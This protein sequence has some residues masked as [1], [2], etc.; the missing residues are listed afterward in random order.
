MK[1]KDKNNDRL[2]MVKI[3]PKIEEEKLLLVPKGVEINQEILENSSCFEGW[4][5]EETIVVYG[6]DLNVNP[7]SNLEIKSNIEFRE[8]FTSIDDLD[9]PLPSNLLIL[10]EDGCIGTQGY[11]T[12]RKRNS[13]LPDASRG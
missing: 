11:H 4:W 10:D 3:T 2:V 12:Y 1:E 13:K 6:T 5:D 9:S 8:S 7:K